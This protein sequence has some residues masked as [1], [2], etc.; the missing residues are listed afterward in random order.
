M[1]EH[2]KQLLDRAE[3]A[4]AESRRLA[5]QNRS[6]VSESRLWLQRL[7]WTADEMKPRNPTPKKTSAEERTDDLRQMVHEEIE[8]QRKLLEKLRRKSS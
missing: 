8:E 2:L 3:D 7:L 5:H 6:C 1:D 4:I